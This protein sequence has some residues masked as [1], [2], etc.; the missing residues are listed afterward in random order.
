MPTCRTLTH[1]DNDV[2][3]FWAAFF[4]NALKAEKESAIEAEKQSA[5]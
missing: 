3:I 5:L 1:C 2:I 4:R